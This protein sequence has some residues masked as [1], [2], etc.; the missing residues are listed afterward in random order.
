VAAFQNN[1]TDR[2][3]T[4][5]HFVEDAEREHE[6]EWSEAVDKGIQAYMDGDERELQKAGDRIAK[7]IMDQIDRVKSGTLKKSMEATIE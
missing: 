7:D 6:R 2:G 3:V 4:P 1:G 5:A